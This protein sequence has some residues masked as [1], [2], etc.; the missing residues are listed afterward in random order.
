MNSILSKI[1]LK[2]SAKYF[3]G[4]KY[5]AFSVF[6]FLLS[7]M[8]IGQ[9]NT[10]KKNIADTTQT[11]L[12]SDRPFETLITQNPVYKG[13]DM[14]LVE[15]ITQ[16][17]IYPK[18]ELNE[19]IGGVVIIGFAVEKDGSTSEHKILRGIENGKRLEKE[20]LRVCKLI[21]YEQPAIQNNKPVRFSILIPVSFNLE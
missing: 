3:D 11:H 9:N 20:A 4:T 18:R 1:T 2:G 21:R 19:K 14:A 10:P 5:L 15:F 12:N 16:N 17:I 6:L 7:S 13:G 8:I